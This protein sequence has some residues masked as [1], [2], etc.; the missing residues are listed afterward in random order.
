MGGVLVG[1]LSRIAPRE[2]LAGHGELAPTVEAAFALSLLFVS[3]T[4]F[5]LVLDCLL[6]SLMTLIP[7]RNGQKCLESSP[8]IAWHYA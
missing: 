2:R 7:R 3:E 6:F 8:R 1:K 4:F 5:S